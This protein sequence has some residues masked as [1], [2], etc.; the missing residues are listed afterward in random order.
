MLVNDGEMLVNDGEMSMRSYT[1][2]TIIDEFFTIIN[3]HFTII[4]EHF[5]II[6]LKLTILR[7]FDHH[8]E[9]APTAYFL[10]CN[11]LFVDHVYIHINRNCHNTLLV[12]FSEIQ[13]WF[14]NIS[15]R[16]QKEDNYFVVVV[17][18]WKSLS[19]T[20]DTLLNLII[21]LTTKTRFLY[22]IHFLMVGTQFKEDVCSCF[23]FTLSSEMAIA[24]EGVEYS[25]LVFV[26]LNN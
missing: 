6:S 23:K 5:T 7:S 3:R 14:V 20:L 18:A 22:L 8:W 21:K 24:E 9:A 17:E 11:R 19:W 25:Q 10:A 4:N 13:L 26:K 12:P 16:L 2:F 15:P 1:H